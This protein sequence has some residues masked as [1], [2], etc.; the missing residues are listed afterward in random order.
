[1]AEAVKNNTEQMAKLTENL[2]KEKRFEDLEKAMKEKE[3]RQMLY[4]EYH[5]C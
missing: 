1:M 2:L 5:I 4:E 3:Y